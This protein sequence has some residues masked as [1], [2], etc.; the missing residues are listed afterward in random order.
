MYQVE[1][2]VIKSDYLYYYRRAILKNVSSKFDGFLAVRSQ[3]DSDYGVYFYAPTCCQSA[4]F[5]PLFAFYCPLFF[6]E[7]VFFNNVRKQNVSKM[8]KKYHFKLKDM[9]ITRCIVPRTFLG[10]YKLLTDDFPI[11]Q[12][13]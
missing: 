2:D 1:T 6:Y 3:F 7:I 12:A 4:T 13:S 10:T 11:V 9:S 5:G 8:K